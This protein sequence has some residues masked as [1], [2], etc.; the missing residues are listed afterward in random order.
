MFF[1][2]TIA[3]AEYRNIITGQT[4]TLR[5]KRS[6]Q[7]IPAATYLITA[8]IGGED[9]GIIPAWCANAT[10]EHEARTLGNAWHKKL[11]QQYAM[12]RK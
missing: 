3:H 9:D 1:F 5:I 7:T 8:N 12:K 10:T 6:H 4:A 11:T 2:D